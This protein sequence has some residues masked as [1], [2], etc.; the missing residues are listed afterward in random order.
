MYFYVYA[1]SENDAL[2]YKSNDG[3]AFA[4]DSNRKPLSAVIVPGPPQIQLLATREEAGH[5][6]RD[7]R[8]LHIQQSRSCG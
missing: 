3:S 6:G 7:S 8:W 4:D 1:L 2:I 5:V